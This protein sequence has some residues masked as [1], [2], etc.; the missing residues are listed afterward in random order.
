MP[1]I[2]ELLARID[3]LEAQQ[4]A[5]PA[6]RYRGVWR[7]DQEYGAGDFCTHRGSVWFTDR[8]TAACPGDTNSS[9]VLAVKKGRDASDETN[10]ILRLKQLEHAVALLTRDDRRK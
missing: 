8:A 3:A 2:D 4:R 7:A 6:I 9:W 1:L 10:I 5:M